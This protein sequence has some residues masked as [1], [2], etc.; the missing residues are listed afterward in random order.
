[1]DPE[2]GNVE[3]LSGTKNDFD[4][5]VSNCFGS[6][7]FCGVSLRG[8]ENQVKGGAGT[9]LALAVGGMKERKHSDVT[10]GF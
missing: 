2:G 8:T 5:L 1:M 6:K 10:S 3:N 4:S 7:S 9:D